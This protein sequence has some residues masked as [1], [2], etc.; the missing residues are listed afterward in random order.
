VLLF[1][2]DSIWAPDLIVTYIRHLRFSSASVLP[3]R[4]EEVLG[5]L[6]DRYK[7]WSTYADHL[8]GV[9]HNRIVKQIFTSYE[10]FTRCCFAF[11]KPNPAI[12]L[13]IQ[14]VLSVSI[15]YSQ[16]CSSLRYD[17]P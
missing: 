8:Y 3:L 1:V 14:D 12:S 6:V 10:I 17:T 5:M 11:C 13:K 16:I 4:E 9:R 2:S 15:G 7:V